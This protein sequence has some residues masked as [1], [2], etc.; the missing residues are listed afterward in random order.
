MKAS[1]LLLGG[2]CVLTAT[3]A[4]AWG[5]PKANVVSSAKKSKAAKTPLAKAPL[6]KAPLAKALD[7]EKLRRSLKVDPLLSIESVRRDVASNAGRVVEARGIVSGTMSV[8]GT[9]SV[10]LRLDDASTLT[11]ALPAP[12]TTAAATNSAPSTAVASTEV[13]STATPIFPGS[14]LLQP[15]ARVRVLLLV[16]ASGNALGD[17][18][19]DAQNGAAIEASFT[20]LAVATAPKIASFVGDGTVVISSEGEEAPLSG[21]SVPN[22]VPPMTGR[23]RASI[24]PE[25]PPAQ[26]PAI[27][28]TRPGIDPDAN[29]FESQKPAYKNLVRRFN[30]KLSDA[31]VDEIATALLRAGYEN[32]MDPRFLAA[33]IATESDFD[34]YCLSGSG[35]MG[36][37]Q[38]MPFNLKE[39]RITNAWNPTQ[40]VLGTARLLRGH[41]NDYRNR[42]D[43]TLLAVAAYN[44]GPGAVRRAGY[45][46][47]PGKQ[48]QRYVRKVYNRYREFAPD[49]FK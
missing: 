14:E 17:A 24:I 2:W 42:P 26:P 30:S 33:I 23:P 12:V 4:N 6:T 11:F 21:S 40:N 1:F 29:D 46:V 3:T 47:P 36:L 39:A 48:V 31:Q 27:V 15:G 28:A 49:M 7:Y 25:P 18:A 45:R 20:P 41:L 19:S 43:G 8:A 10:V 5:A 44:A 34:I 35:A 13:T 38:L 16:V 9:R 37:G 32:S 22:P